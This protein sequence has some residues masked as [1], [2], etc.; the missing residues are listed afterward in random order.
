MYSVLLLFQIIILNQ[1]FPFFLLFVGSRFALI[2]IKSILYNLLLHFSFQPNEKIQIP[3]KLQKN[4]FNMAPEN[5]MHSEQQITQIKF[6][7][8]DGVWL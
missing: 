1:Q 5:G 3:V 6:I 2:E 4:G 8:Y 7:L